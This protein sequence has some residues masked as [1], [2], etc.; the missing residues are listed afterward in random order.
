MLVSMDHA[1][2]VI[3]T[4]GMTICEACPTDHDG[5]YGAG[6][7]CSVACAR[8][9]STR[10]KR[11]DINRRVS[12][13]LKGRITP[14]NSGFR[15]P[16]I[17]AKAL[18]TKRRRIIESFESVVQDSEVKFEQLSKLLK[19]R[20][21][22]IDQEYRCNR[23]GNGEWFGQP[24]PLE[25]EHKDGDRTN[26]AREN[27]ECLCPNCHSLTV[28]WRG[29]NRSN[30]DSV[31]DDQIA[32]SVMANGNIHKALLSLGMAPKGKNYSRFNRVVAERGIKVPDAKRA[33]RSEE[34]RFAIKLISDGMSLTKAARRINASSGTVREALYRYGYK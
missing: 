9:F 4:A 17:K 24:L 26:D 28:T 16:E 19:R 7:F 34:I 8:S 31:T 15:N 27:L 29:R 11:N 6:R 2:S 25:L 3:H 14:E 5:S 32:E 33:L 18:D 1:Q 20:S 30:K 22:L 10:S 23:C 12:A 21:V 13:S